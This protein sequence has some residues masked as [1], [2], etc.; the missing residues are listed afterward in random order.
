MYTISRLSIQSIDTS[1]PVPHAPLVV[2][3]DRVETSI[4]S[5][6]SAL[7]GPATPPRLAQALE[8]AVMSGGGRVRPHL[9]VS[10]SIASG[11]LHPEVADAGAAA[12][13]LLHCASLVHDDLPCFDD[14]PVRRG[15]PSV[16]AAHGEALAVLAGDGLII[17][18]FE[19]LASVAATHAPSLVGPLLASLGTGVGTRTGLV[20]GQAWESESHL[21]LRAYHRA[22]TGALFVAAARAGALAGGADPDAWT[23]VGLRLGEAYQVADDL[24]DVV[25]R[26]HEIGKPVGQDALLGR[27]NAVAQLGVSGAYARLERLLADMLD[28][29]PACPGRGELRAS[30]TELCGRVFPARRSDPSGAYPRVDTVVPA[31]VA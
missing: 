3:A 29:I 6:L 12:I 4:R 21:E 25:A 15:R 13:E 24:R 11:D 31:S 23:A 19:H 18:A 22:K 26:E 9:V 10:V 8:H 1:W 14:A 28:A 5:A 7:N 2:L 27:P 17:G 16:H 20:A 30:L